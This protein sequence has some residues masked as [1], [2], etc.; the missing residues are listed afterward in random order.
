MELTP[1]GDTITKLIN[2][3]VCDYAASHAKTYP[4]KAS[5]LN[6]LKYM[7]Y[8]HDVSRTDIAVEPNTIYIRSAD[9][10]DSA[11]FTEDWSLSDQVLLCDYVLQPKCIIPILNSIANVLQI[12][13]T[14]TDI[15][16]A[17]LSKVHDA[18]RLQVL[19]ANYIVRLDHAYSKNVSSFGIEDVNYVEITQLKHAKRLIARQLMKRYKN[20]IG[21]LTVRL[22]EISLKQPEYKQPEP[23]EE[24]YEDR[25]DSNPQAPRERHTSTLGREAGNNDTLHHEPLWDRI[26]YSAI[27]LYNTLRDIGYGN[28]DGP[29][30]NL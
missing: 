4:L 7:W 15:D 20:H 26:K 6:Q 21:L 9:V 5:D 27:D 30:A 14:S 17:Y 23:E 28:T 3:L 22:L 25:P 16:H 12:K 2:T 29:Y 18:Y 13:R 8:P 24:T 10:L 11:E 19:H 1:C